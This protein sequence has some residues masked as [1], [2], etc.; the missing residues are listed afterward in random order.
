MIRLRII[1][2]G[3]YSFQSNSVS[4]MFLVESGSMWVAMYVGLSTTVTLLDNLTAF[5]N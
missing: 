3:A 1:N 4:I 5:P 2:Q